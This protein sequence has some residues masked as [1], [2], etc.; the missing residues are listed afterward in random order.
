ME[1]H[2]DLVITDWMMP[3]LWLICLSAEGDKEPLAFRRPPD[4][5][6]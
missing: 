6:K 5:R 1:S 4:R 2:P 3:A